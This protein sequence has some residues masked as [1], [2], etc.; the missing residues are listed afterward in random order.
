[1]NCEQIVLVFTQ[2]VNT[3]V[4]W[5]GSNIPLTWRINIMCVCVSTGKEMYA[6]FYY[7]CSKK[8]AEGTYFDKLPA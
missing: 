1:M 5:R 6:L 4:D 8:N 3:Y 2:K 7:A